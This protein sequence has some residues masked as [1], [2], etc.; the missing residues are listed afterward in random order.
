MV[1]AATDDEERPE[2]PTPAAPQAPDDIRDTVEKTPRS[3][4]G[5]Q[6]VEYVEEDLKKTYGRDR[7]HAPGAWATDKVFVKGVGA[8]LKGFK[9]DSIEPEWSTS[10]GGPICD[11]TRHVTVDGRTAVLFQAREDSGDRGRRTGGE[12]RSRWRGGGVPSLT[13]WP[14]GSDSGRARE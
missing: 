1:W 10:L 12:G 7:V 9:F 2:R 5:G 3:V 13:T 6:A 11:T 14:A 8:G 4:V